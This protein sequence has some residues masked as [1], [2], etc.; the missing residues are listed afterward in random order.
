M[1]VKMAE[2]NNVASAAVVSNVNINTGSGASAT[3]FSAPATKKRSSV[4]Q[5][6]HIILS[7][8]LTLG[9]HSIVSPVRDGR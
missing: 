7:L 6:F 9:T 8:F 4:Q 5:V 3:T 1:G 2:A